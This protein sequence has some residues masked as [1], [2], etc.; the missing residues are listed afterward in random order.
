LLVLLEELS[1]KRK[2]DKAKLKDLGGEV[3]EDEE[4]VEGD[5]E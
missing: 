2:A 5:S 1:L 3:S 4:E